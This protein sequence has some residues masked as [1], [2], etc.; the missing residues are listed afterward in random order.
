MNRLKKL[1]K[2]SNEVMPI[3]QLLPAPFEWVDIPGGQVTLEGTIFEIQPFK[4]AKYPITKAQFHI[5]EADPTGYSAPQWWQF[6]PETTY[7][8]SWRAT[9]SAPMSDYTTNPQAPRTAVSWYEAIGFCRWLTHKTGLTITLPTEQQWQ[10][11]AQ[12]D[13]GRTFPWGNEYDSSCCNQELSATPVDQYPS[14]AS[15]FGVMDM[16]SNISQWCLNSYKEGH[17]DMDRYSE[18]RVGR[19]GGRKSKPQ[20]ASV[21]YRHGYSP[22]GMSHEVGFRIVCSV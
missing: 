1:F 15:P 14:G 11:A 18:Y 6:A 16:V 7:Q 4:I 21:T 2:K 12:G 19:G 13:D 22:E 20:N 5:F 9:H 8:R 3:T 17:V 10:R